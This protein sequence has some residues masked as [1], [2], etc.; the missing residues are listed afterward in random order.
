MT[1]LS[2]GIDVGNSNCFISSLSATGEVVHEGKMVETNN[3]EEWRELLMGLSSC[4]ELRAAFEIGPHYDWLYDLLAEYCSDV[5][6]INTAD[7]VPLQQRILA[8]RRN[9]WIK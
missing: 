6:V 7:F 9:A 2:I 8:E 1:K 5:E 4:F 3:E